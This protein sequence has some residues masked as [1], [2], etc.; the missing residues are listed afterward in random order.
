MLDDITY[1]CHN[2]NH[3][4]AK[5]P[6]MFWTWISNYITLFCN[7]VCDGQKHIQMSLY[8][9]MSILGGQL[10]GKPLK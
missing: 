5:Q 7:F 3:S 8:A 10:K 6:L 9:A 4:L 1:A 2:I